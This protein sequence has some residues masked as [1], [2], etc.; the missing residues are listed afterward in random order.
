MLEQVYTQFYIPDLGTVFKMRECITF[1]AALNIRSSSQSR[2]D[3][4]KSAG[5][6]SNSPYTAVV[7]LDN[8]T[9]TFMLFCLFTVTFCRVTVM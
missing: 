9:S 4:K 1:K 7:V 6:R 2:K 3:A 8:F 5:W